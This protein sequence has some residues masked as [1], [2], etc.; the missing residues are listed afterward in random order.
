MLSSSNLDIFHLLLLLCCT[1]SFLNCNFFNCFSFSIVF[2]FTFNSFFCIL[3]F[4]GAIH[5]FVMVLG[6]V[7]MFK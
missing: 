2:L 3:M 6:I 4:I 7:D 5:V 1:C